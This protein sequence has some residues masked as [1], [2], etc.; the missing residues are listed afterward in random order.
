MTDKASLVEDLTK[1]LNLKED[2]IQY[3]AYKGE[4]EIQEIIALIECEL[5]EPYTIFTYRFFL[6]NWPE[7]CFLARDPSGQ[8]VG[9][10]ISKKSIHNHLQRGYIGM[11][12]VDKRYRRLGIGMKREKEEHIR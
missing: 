5:S 2:D 7:L 11:I 10:V 9:I 12:V 8:L 6:N 4:I 1:K 3:T